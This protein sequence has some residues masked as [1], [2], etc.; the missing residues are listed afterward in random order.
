MVNLLGMELNIFWLVLNISALFGAISYGYLILRLTFPD[1]RMLPDQKKFG[2]AATLG[3]ITVI[4][5]L[6][7]SLAIF[8]SVMYTFPILGLAAAIFSIGLR[9]WASADRGKSKVAVP[10]ARSRGRKPE[11]KE[12]EK[13]EETSEEPEEPEQ[14]SEEIKEEKSKDFSEKLKGLFKR[15][16][17]EEEPEEEAEEV[18]EMKEEK[19]EE[20]EVEEEGPEMEREPG[21][22]DYQDIVGKTIPEVKEKAQ[23]FTKE[24]YKKLLKAEEQNKDRKTLKNWIEDQLTEEKPEKE[25]EI[26]EEKDRVIEEP[27]E[28][29]VEEEP[30]IKP[31]EEKKKIEE[32]VKQRKEEKES[33]EKVQEPQVRKPEEIREERRR[34]KEPEKSKRKGR[35]RYL[36]HKEGKTEESG[37][38]RTSRYQRYREKREKP[39]SVKSEEV[40]EMS[41]EE[42]LGELPSLDMDDLE[43]G[44]EEETEIESMLSGGLEDEE[45][46]EALAGVSEEKELDEEEEQNKCPS[47]GATNST[48]I[49]CPNCGEGSCTDCAK[50][51]KVKENFIIYECP[52]CGKQII[53]QK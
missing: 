46:L 43:A 22:A 11:P 13:L 49:Y 9:I 21:K 50:K 35:R 5:S 37:K 48:V 45:E 4:P 23:D 47:C 14:E 18:E 32:K 30:E 34:S 41:S 40:Q 51:I 38:E 2:F 7:I 10:T 19:F 52:K 42:S 6:I 3:L 24:Q 36:K 15:E 27:E 25:E 44:T 26:E 8:G 31:E 39:E 12:S 16:K 20:P 17:T 53:V 28:E 1:I 33:G 29:E